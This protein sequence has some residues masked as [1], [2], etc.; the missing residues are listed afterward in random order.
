MKIKIIFLILV[1]LSVI[2]FSYYISA[3]KNIDYKKASIKCLKIKSNINS[4][5]DNERI[6]CIKD[7]IR[8]SLPKNEIGLAAKELTILAANDNIF[9]GDCH[10]AMHLLG[11]EIL[12]Y[13]KNIETAIENVNFIDCGNGLSHG[14][15]D[16]WS[17]NKFTDEELKS[18]IKSCDNI[19]KISPG[20]C[21][22]GIGHALIQSNEK[23]EF[24][25]RLKNALSKCNLF[26]YPNNSWHCAYGVMMQPFFKQ[27][28]DL[29]KE[30]GMEIPDP[31]FLIEI[32]NKYAV[33][34]KDVYHGCIS[35]AGWLMGLKETLVSLKINESEFIISS[36]KVEEYITSD[37][38]YVIL[39]ENLKACENSKNSEYSKNC[40]LQMFSRLPL[41]WYIGK[42]KFEER[43]N[44]IENKFIR[45][46]LAGG[47]E[48]IPPNEFKSIVLNND[49]KYNVKELVINRWNRERSDKIPF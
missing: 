2:L 36:E 8:F 38:F 18:A 45:F 25:K 21:A 10:L 4:T 27:N 47:Y 40:I 33:D 12:S 37:K 14:V 34:N 31:F 49:K 32:C 43:C 3:N 13:Y 46:C 11:T 44:I 42:T 5:N 30:E 16:Q 24:D 1:T 35:G 22:E 41:P 39:K 48:F 15:L 23:F 29:I 20:G 6:E 17:F 26:M 19:E 28:P 7:I 9:Y